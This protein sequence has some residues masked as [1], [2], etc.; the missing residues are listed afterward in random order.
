MIRRGLAA[1]GAGA[2]LALP[3]PNTPALAEQIIFVPGH[4][5]FIAI[6][7]TA[8]W[9]TNKG[10]VERWSRRGML[11]E[12][13]M[14]EPCGAMAV[15]AGSLWVADCT[16][17]TLNRINVRT[18][19]KTA[20][21]RT[22]IAAPDG[23]LNVVFGAGSVWVASDKAGTISRISPLSNKVIATVRV[24]PGSQYLAFGYGALWAVSASGRSL[25]KIDPKLN[26]VVARTLLGRDPGFLVAGER[27]VWVQEQGDGTVARIDP[28]TTRI[29]GRIKVG[30]SLK[31]G[32]I[33]AGGG[34]IWLRTTAD[35]TFVVIDPSA[36]TIRAR[37]G[38]PSGSGSLR[39]TA[40]GIWT[41]AHDLQTLSWWT[42]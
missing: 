35:Q 33:D 38:K 1:I 2:V 34:K 8:V 32:D 18:A 12:V 42:R 23:E 31:Y 30:E 27:S 37:M 4:A 14:T 24:D 16:A 36:M 9:V 11:A 29:S 5:D 10:R 40:A 25:Q 22:G 7:R 17:L 39:Y 19:A 13:Q 26:R 20:V 41:T 21:I 28:K 15:A 6:D 3:L